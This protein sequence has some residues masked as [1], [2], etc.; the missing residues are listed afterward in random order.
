MT[1]TSAIHMCP[2]I[3]LSLV[4]DGV[5]AVTLDVSEAGLVRRTAVSVTGSISATF[6]N[7]I[8]TSMFGSEKILIY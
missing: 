8:F 1:L 5:E 3:K 2:F 4:R 7:A 6:S